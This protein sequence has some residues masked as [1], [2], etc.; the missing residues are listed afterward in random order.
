MLSINVKADNDVA[1]SEDHTSAIR[2]VHAA[3]LMLKVPQYI[4]GMES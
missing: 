2:I 4:S 1:S 3:P